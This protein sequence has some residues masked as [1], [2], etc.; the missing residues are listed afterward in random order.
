MSVI[1]R[2]QKL[3]RVAKRFAKVMM[4]TGATQGRGALALGRWKALPRVGDMIGA[5]LLMSA[6]LATSA[7]AN[8]CNKSGYPT[9]TNCQVR[10]QAGISYGG[11]ETKGWAY[12]CTGDHPYYWLPHFEGNNSCFSIA[13]NKFDE[14]DNKFSATITNWCFNKQTLVISLGCGTEPK[15]SGPC[16]NSLNPNC[17]FG[18]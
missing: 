11:W 15:R 1:E 9:P 16:A 4:I 17:P 6:L 5:G 13:E 2:R 14:N 8:P 10:A 18:P 12:Y 3:R 7:W